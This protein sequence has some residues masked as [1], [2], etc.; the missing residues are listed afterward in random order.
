MARS[1]APNRMGWLIDPDKELIFV[2]RSDRT[3]AVFDRPQDKLPAV[4]DFATALEFTVGKIDRW[5][6]N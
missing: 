2:Y 1:D 6:E 3:I 4:P 5:L